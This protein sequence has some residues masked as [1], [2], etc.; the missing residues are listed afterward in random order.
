MRLHVTPDEELR[1]A[2]RAG[3]RAN[4]GY[5]PCIVNSKGKD[6]YRCIC[7]EMREH[8]QVGE[9]CHCGLYIKDEM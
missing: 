5:C 6:E 4:D 8:V 7:E 1:E 3:L 9:T 2:V